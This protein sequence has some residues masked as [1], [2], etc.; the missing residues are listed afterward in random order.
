M[1][2]G[3][4]EGD[5]E[6]EGM[7][8]AVSNTLLRGFVSGLFC[9][10]SPWLWAPPG[11]GWVKNTMQVHWRGFRAQ[12]G[13]LLMQCVYFPS[14]A[15]RCQAEERGGRNMY[16]L[17]PIRITHDRFRFTLYSCRISEAAG[18]KYRQI[19]RRADSFANKRRIWPP[20]HK[21]GRHITTN[22]ER[23]HT[24]SELCD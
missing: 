4:V 5:G 16:G 8:P 22:G 12:D 21:H 23:N 24:K 2:V 10:Q 14:D 15:G 3:V 7:L 19:R 20:A 13:W 11:R 18:P 17:W 6:G 1:D 9:R